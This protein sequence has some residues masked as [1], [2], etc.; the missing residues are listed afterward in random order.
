MEPNHEIDVEPHRQE[1]GQMPGM[2]DN[3]LAPSFRELSAADTSRRGMMWSSIGVG[4][5]VIATGIYFLG[6]WLH[7]F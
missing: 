7:W 4:A 2:N 1:F 5:L 6:D 3:P